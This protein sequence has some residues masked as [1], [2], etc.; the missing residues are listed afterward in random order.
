M[1]IPAVEYA[2]DQRVQAIAEAA[3]RLNELRENWLN[4][5]DL[6]ERVPEVVEGYPERIV[7][8]D[9][10]AAAILKKRTLTNLYNERPALARPRPQG[11][12]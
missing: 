11:S 6:V 8:K 12:R 4:P 9:E 7:P 2:D 10:K 3:Q 5:E 1:D